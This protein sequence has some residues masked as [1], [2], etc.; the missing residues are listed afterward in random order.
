MLTGVRHT[1]CVLAIIA[2][3]GAH[4]ADVARP[5]GLTISVDTA[6]AEAVLQAATGTAA[7]AGA[8]A[9][10]TLALPAIR[11]M[12]A[13]EHRYV[14]EAS[15]ESWR[16]ALTGL[17]D[18][19][20]G[21]PFD[22]RGLRDR[23]EAVRELLATLASRHDEVT[24]R[25]TQRLQR[26]APAGV[27]L[28]ATLSVVLGSHQNGWVPDQN[29]P[30]FYVDAGFHAPDADALVAVAAHELFHLVQGAAQPDLGAAL[31]DSASAV[32]A[33][34]IAHNVHAALLNLVIEGM[35]DYVGDPA[36]FPGSGAGI[37]RAR[38]EYARNHARRSETFALFD[39]LIFRLARDSQAPLGPLLSIGFGGTWDQT[40]YYVGYDMAAAIDRHLGS[41][42]LRA[43]VTLAPEDFVLDYVRACE[44]NATDHELVPLAPSTIEGVKMS[45]AALVAAAARGS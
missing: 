12:I 26:F 41:E 45:R 28:R 43:L 29:T 24:A 37:T 32:P 5:P 39:T 23:P 14:P 27:E 21:L 19:G 20:N 25:L 11:A 17:A 34:R 8:L 30:I 13:K 3:P 42:R 6:P 31:A 15:V 2:A 1:L 33:E 22:L 18:G 9:D 7:Q 40:G 16:L 44:D 4:S 38:R 36:A 35:A 10:A